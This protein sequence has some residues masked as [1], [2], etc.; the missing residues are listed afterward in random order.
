[1]LI[2][3]TLPAD[4]PKD[5]AVMLSILD[6]AGSELISFGSKPAGYADWDDNKKM[7]EPGPWIAV[8]PGMNRFQ[9]NL[10]LAGA[11]KV[12]GNKTAGEANRGPFV[13]PG[14]Y[15]VRLCIGED[16]TVECFRVINDPRVD[17]SDQALTAQFE[18]L[19]SAIAKI[20]EAHNGVS[21][22]RAVRGQVDHW[23]KRLND[24]AAVVAK[25]EEI[26]KKLADVEDALIQPGDQK[27]TYS[28]T[29]RPR[30]NSKLSSLLPIMGSADA[31]PTEAAIALVAD[32]SAQIDGQLSTLERIIE[33]DIHELNRLI[34]SA[35]AP[36]VAI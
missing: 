18:A 6:A 9:W 26:L 3:Y 30:L 29:D 7:M 23:H 14:D 5:A 12:L 17:V 33:E 34:L 15:Q 21:R 19:R 28:L 8:K 24:E 4:L 2:H 10:R 11:A 35:D 25:A 22:L 31:A 1:M 36:P 13:L 20:S 16:C 27:N 32:Y